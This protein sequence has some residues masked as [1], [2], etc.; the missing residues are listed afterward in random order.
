V[1]RLCR[2]PN[3][4]AAE[5]DIESTSIREANAKQGGTRMKFFWGLFDRVSLKRFRDLSIQQ[6][7]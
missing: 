1:T 3:P 2:P 7:G 5:Y 6:L 4:R